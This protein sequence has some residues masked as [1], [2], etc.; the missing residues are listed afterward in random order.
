[1]VL[2][3]L[4]VGVR[5]LDPLPVHTL[6]S[7]YFDFLQVLAP[8]PYQD[9]PVRVVD[10]DERALAE[11][12]QWP[13]PRDTLAE[14]TDRLT[15]LGAAVI[16][17]DVLFAEPDRYSP[18]E[19]IRRPSVAA[20]LGD[21]VNAEELER[22]D[23]DSVFAGAIARSPVVLGLAVAT[24]GGGSGADYLRAGFVQIGS[25]PA[26]GLFRIAQTTPILP[27]LADAAAG[28]GGINVSPLTDPGRVRQVPLVWSAGDGVIASLGLEAL[29]VA[30]GES[31]LI[32][33]GLE[34]VEGASSGV[35]MGGYAIPLTTA[36]EIWVRYRPDD[37]RL[38]VSAADVLGE[39]PTRLRP[40]IEGQIVLIGTSAAGLF[41]LR[42]SALGGVVPGVSI[43]AQIIE[44]ILT[45][46]YLVRNDL[47]AG[48]EIL[49]LV[50]LGLLT[51]MM[52]ARSRPIL[53]LAGGGV[54]ALG[55][56]ASSWFAFRDAGLLID[57]SFPVI[58]GA[59]NFAIL[60][61]W[62][63]VFTDRDKRKLR[64]SF[65]Q[66]L[67]PS[68]LSEME[69]SDYNIALG[70]EVREIT[71]LFSDIRD[72]TVLSHE[73]PVEVL[74]P[75][76]NGLFTDLSAEILREEGTIDKFI[77]DS[78]M[79]FWNAPLQVEN[80]E[81]RSALAALGMRRA[82][83]AFNARSDRRPINIGV[84]LHAGPASVGNF[85]SEQ[86]F[87]YSAIGD[88]V[89]VAARIESSA[90]HVAFDLI[91]SADVRNAAQGLAWLDAGA[92]ALKGVAERTPV[93]VLV[94]G[95]GM[96][97]SDPFLRLLEAHDAL[98]RAIATPG[99]DITEVLRTCAELGVGIERR[100][101]SFY[102]RIPQRLEDFGAE[103]SALSA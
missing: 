28:I 80:H 49:A 102:A 53:A 42:T 68:V 39:D 96:A 8:R 58:G 65:A 92:L 91:A 103:A 81:A 72:F 37:P 18:A 3:T 34:N 88:A 13:W 70:G 15:Q 6:R 77:G 95:E 76:L 63:F 45:D 84:G 35:Q 40:A 23:T 22:L 5:S 19:L 26:A 46:D 93:H 16:A 44:Q 59:V 79:A 30:L 33:R 74:V 62:R 97:R 4:L 83:D 20:A 87:S 52:L 82:L 66:Y 32:L 55:V 38:Y 73:T 56:I 98:L 67:A 41:D 2:L 31:T 21:S 61:A 54:A 7:G 9:L 47:I 14:M 43:H 27:E 64:S 50:V 29:R 57:A 24:D 86:R 36:G 25:N 10:I 51:T 71:I 89:N 60:V 99:A 1:M 11:V 101:E 69:Q 100:L 12:G 78:V 75:L 17:Y 85:G 48:L 90:K 94:G